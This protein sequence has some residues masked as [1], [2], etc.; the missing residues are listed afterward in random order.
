[1]P[2]STKTALITGSSRGIGAAIARTLHRDGWRVVINYRD[3]QSSAE[4]LAE[5]LSAVAVKADVSNFD[6]VSAMFESVGEMDLLVNNAATHHYG[7]FGDMEPA[8]WSRLLDVNLTG[9]YNCLK[10]AI[11]SMVRRKSG[12]IINV[13]SV[14][15]IHGASCETAYSAT[16]AAIIGLTRSLAKELGPSDI[17]VNCVAPG[18]ILT[19][20]LGDF[21]P[22]ELLSLCDRTP[23]GRLGFPDDVADAVAFLASDSARYITG[24]VLGVD[25]G[26]PAH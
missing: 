10:F 1:M 26:F 9:V 18:V 14:W 20:M 22:D 21:T 15:G 12:C 25:G 13:S 16:K 2:E 19:D 5:E 6:E 23:L 7:L 11:P 4:S 17:R 8:E 3:S 24:Q